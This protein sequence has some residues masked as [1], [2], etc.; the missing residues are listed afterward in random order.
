MKKKDKQTLALLALLG[1]GAYYLL[2]QPPRYAPRFHSVPPPPPPGTQSYQ[3][4]VQGIL[5]AF[6][7]VAALWQPGGPF[8]TPPGTPAAP[9]TPPPPPG[10]PGPVGIYGRSA[11]W[12]LLFL[13]PG[14]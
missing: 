14:I 1:I 8:Y 2:N 9:G 10:A 6:G 3:I 12:P 4:W 7:Q 11:K 13:L 5:K